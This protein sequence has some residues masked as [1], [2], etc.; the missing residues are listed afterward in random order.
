L[1]LGTPDGL[2]S[3]RWHNLSPTN[4]LKTIDEIGANLLN[5]LQSEV[6]NLRRWCRGFTKPMKTRQINP[7][8]QHPSSAV[9]TVALLAVVLFSV[10]AAT[11]STIVSPGAD[12][13]V[14]GGSNNGYPFN[15][16]FFGLSTMRYQQVYNSSEFSGAG[17]PML[18]TGIAFRPDTGT[19]SAFSSTLSSVQIDLSTT[20]VNASTLGPV[21]ASNVGLNDTVVFNGALSLSSSYTGPLGGPKTFDIVITL[22]TPFVYNSA[23][24]NLLLDVRNFGGGGTTQFDS[25]VLP[26]TQRVWSGAVGDASGTNIGDTGLITQFIYTPV[27]EPQ[28]VALAALALAAMAP[29]RLRQSKR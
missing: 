4:L 12:T 6:T 28:V 23:N 14:E 19:G 18:I 25:D 15:L 3:F 21:F 20:S 9:V 5:K 8:S 29:G 7:S 22:T 13:S 11:A 26:P 17:G 27:P 24:G 2:P 16:S 1:A 10:F